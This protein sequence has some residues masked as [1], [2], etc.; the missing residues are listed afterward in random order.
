MSMTLEELI[1]EVVSEAVKEYEKSID[2]ALQ[3]AL[4]R[5]NKYKSEITKKLND[6]LATIRKEAR[7]MSLKMMSQAELEAKKTYL[8]SIEEVVETIIKEA[9]EKVKEI[10]GTEMYEKSLENLTRES[11]EAIGGKSFRISC[12]EDDRE[13]VARTAKR[14]AREMGVEIS[15]DPAPIKTVGG[16]K[17]TNKE[18]TALI[19]NTVEARLERMRSEIRT[20]IIK[21]IMS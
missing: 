18:G 9:V 17:I 2:Q 20:A 11:I 7:I 10:K 1:R 8:Q 6:E 5:L 12:S 15:I 21:E 16:V 13:L 3:E 19:D 4:I 14:I